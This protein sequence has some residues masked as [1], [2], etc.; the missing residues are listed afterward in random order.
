MIEAAQDM[1][2]QRM[3]E[4]AKKQT[5]QYYEMRSDRE[6][7]TLVP[8]E[9]PEVAPIAE[10]PDPFPN[11]GGHAERRVFKMPPAET[12]LGT[13]KKRYRTTVERLEAQEQQE[14]REQEEHRAKQE[15]EAQ[16]AQRRHRAMNEPIH[17]HPQKSPP[18]YATNRFNRSTVN[19]NNSRNFLES[20]D[21]ETV[22]IMA[23]IWM[24]YQ[25]NADWK[26]LLALAYILVV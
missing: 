13:P 4:E 1:E 23:L 12:Y 26:L 3:I 19:M 16:E 6:V 5:H 10:N 17:M 18:P 25:D 11:T 22:L 8:K 9:V 20:I 7:P 15:R 2:L 14:R 24:L 21:A